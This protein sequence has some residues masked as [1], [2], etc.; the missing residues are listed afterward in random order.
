MNTLQDNDQLSSINNNYSHEIRDIY[1]KNRD[2]SIEISLIRNRIKKLKDEEQNYNKQLITIRE[3]EKKDQKIQQDK[4]KFQKELSTL[5][6]QQ[7]KE[8]NKKRQKIQE[9]KIKFEKKKKKREEENILAKKTEYKIALNNKYLNK[10]IK[11]QMVHQQKNINNCLHEKV[12]QQYN[13][14]MSNKVRSD[15]IKKNKLKLEYEENI[16][17]LKKLEK[18]IQDERDELSRMEKKYLEKKTNNKNLRY[19]KYKKINYPK[20]NTINSNNGNLSDENIL[21]NNNSHIDLMSNNS[22][23]FSKY[24]RNKKCASTSDISSNT[25]VDFCDKLCTENKKNN[26]KNNKEKNINKE[27]STKNKL[28]ITVRI[29]NKNKSMSSLEVDGRKRKSIEKRFVITKRIG[30]KIRNHNKSDI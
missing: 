9:Q 26:K 24:R 17:N 12:R 8:L 22:A 2:M 16:S 4:I 23:I 18:E 14:S 5:K 15:L 6:K 19:L 21:F 28:T 3:F 10:Y 1:K 7:M 11:E 30:N 27:N 29:R 20:Y 25:L 13:E